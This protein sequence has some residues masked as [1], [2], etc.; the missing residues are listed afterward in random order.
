MDL[1]LAGWV[2]QAIEAAAELG[3]ADVLADGPLPVDEVARRVGADSDAVNRL[4]RALA[5]RGVF[6]RLR[7]GRYAL[8]ALAD[9][10][11][12]DAPVSMAGAAL[13][14]GS[15]QHREH[16]SMLTRSIRT[17]RA[18]IPVLR[19]K[20][21]F[22]YLGDDP[23]LAGL[24]NQAM[25]SV[26]ELAEKA[27]VAAYAFTGCSTIVDVGG[28]H[29]R[30]LASIL[31][32]APG[33]RGVLFD[34]AEVV[35]GAPELLA[36]RG[37]ADRVRVEAG[38]F[39]ERVPPDGDVYV[40]KHVIHDWPDDSALVILGQLRAASRIGT[41]LVLVELVIPEHRRDFVGNWADLE[42]L[43][44]ADGRERTAAQY[45]AL[46]ARAGFRMT[47]VIPTA[48]P[49]SLIEATPA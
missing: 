38:S 27:I 15:P 23:E 3:I 29:G 31:H 6:R 9:T 14:Y 10:L 44:G 12:N 46:L 24:F 33:A 39:F 45:A 13:F 8:N 19:G 37:V 47:R 40:L 42:M 7:D 22:D 35:D 28:G 26:S 49:F 18:S 20:P 43:L 25:T 32:S 17:G 41:A 4:L 16:W 1:I 5:G 21:F 11:R 30:L 48:S 34:L 36:A 2:S